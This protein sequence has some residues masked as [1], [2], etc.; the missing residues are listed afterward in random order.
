MWLKVYWFSFVWIK[1]WIRLSNIFVK[2]I[3]TPIKQKSSF[4]LLKLKVLKVLRTL[5][6]FIISWTNQLC[7]N[8]IPWK[9]NFAKSVIRQLHDVPF[10]CYEIFIMFF[11][12]FMN[13]IPWNTKDK[14][15]LPWVRPESNNFQI[16]FR[17]LR[18]CLLS[19]RFVVD[20]L[21]LLGS[22]FKLSFNSEFFSV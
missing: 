20:T 11:I 19:V 13:Q 21:Q 5:N 15:P 14:T 16:E 8:Q 10:F 17:F 22:T 9:T 18:S 2:K 4:K 7:S 12:F 6:L 1:Y 3:L